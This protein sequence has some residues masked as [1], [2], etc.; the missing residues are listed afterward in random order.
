MAEEADEEA[1]EQEDEEEDEEEEEEEATF[2]K[3]SGRGG[4]NRWRRGVK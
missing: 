2:S 3:G 4:M 1:D